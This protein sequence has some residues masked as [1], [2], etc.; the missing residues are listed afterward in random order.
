MHRLI[1][2]GLGLAGALALSIAAPSALAHGDSQQHVARAALRRGDQARFR[3]RPRERGRGHDVRPRFAG[4]VPQRHAAQAGRAR[5]ALFK[6]LGLPIPDPAPG[7]GQSGAV[8][9]NPR[10]IRP[11]SVDET[12]VYSHYS[13]LRSYEDLLGLTRGGSDGLGHLGFAGAAGLS[14]FG[15]DVFNRRF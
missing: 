9:L 4:H 2:R 1:G 12:G 11:G 8:L 7:G 15:R 14:P 3:D 6:A 5:P 13:A 10:Y